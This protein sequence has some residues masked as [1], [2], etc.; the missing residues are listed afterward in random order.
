[1]NLTVGLHTEILNRTICRVGG[2]L[3]LRTGDDR[4]FD[5]EVQ[6]QLERRF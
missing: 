5:A 1:L 6:I 4:A 2:V 3:P